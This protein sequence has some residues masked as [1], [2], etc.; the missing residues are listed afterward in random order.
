MGLDV[1]IITARLPVDVDPLVDKWD[2]LHDGFYFTKEK[3]EIMKRH[4][5]I[6]F[7]GDS[8][9]DIHECRKACL[10]YTSPSPRD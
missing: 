10:L 9:S 6:T 8:D 5:Y 3:A 1:V 2:W 7:I 4:S